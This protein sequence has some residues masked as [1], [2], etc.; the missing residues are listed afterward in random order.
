MKR[1][2]E[3]R[4]S[5]L[6]GYSEVVPAVGGLLVVALVIMTVALAMDRL[7]LDA[8]SGF[9]T[10]LGL[11]V[12]TI[13]VITWLARKEDDPRLVRVLTLGLAF[14][15]GGSLVRYFVITVLYGD[16]A[17]AGVYSDAATEMVRLIKAGV[18]TLVP[19]GLEGRPPE[20]QRIAVVLAAVYVVVG[21]SR[22]AGTFVFAWLAFGGRILLWRALKRAVPEADQHRYLLLVLFFPSLAFWPSSIGKEALM[23]FSIGLVSYGAA[24]LFSERVSLGS[25]FTFGA[26]VV[27][28]LFV[29]PHMAAIAVAALGLASV[30]STLGSLKR[31]SQMKATLLRAG[32]LVLLVGIAV[33][34]FTQTSQFLGDEEAGTSTSVNTGEATGVEGVLEGTKAQTSIGGSVF[35]APSVN[36]PLDLPWA[37]VTVLFRPFPWEASSG[38]GFIAA[39]EGLGLLALFGASWRRVASGF[40]MMLRRPYL[41]FVG[42]FTVVFITAFSFI[43]NFGILTRQRTQLLPLVFVFLAMPRMTR[44]RGLFASA[45]EDLEPG[46]DGMVHDSD[47]TSELLGADPSVST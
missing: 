2:A 33:V 7:A 20:S 45:D 32:A 13:P 42:V 27:A 40:V 10:L 36:S 34:V 43:G 23:T 8:I 5:W 37:T 26:G 12:A 15:V 14:T 35:D 19:P 44:A 21:V 11:V 25:V 29:R 30:I 16:N 17:D 31:G 1:R 3:G 24:Q 41:V 38:T 6:G 4:G 22:W 39:L 9:I 46:D 47:E 18:F 28:L